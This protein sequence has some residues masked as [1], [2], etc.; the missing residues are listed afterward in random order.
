MGAKAKL[1]AKLLKGAVGVAST[2]GVPGA[3]LLDKGIGV[4]SKLK[5]A[6]AGASAKP[7][8][9]PGEKG[10]KRRR[11]IMYY[12]KRIPVEKAKARLTRIKMSAYKGL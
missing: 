2:L 12:M 6:S 11:G 3:G 10:K 7:G 4:V 8:A 1:G 9:K 5:G